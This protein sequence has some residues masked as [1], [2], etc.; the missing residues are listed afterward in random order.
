MGRPKALAELHVTPYVLRNNR[1]DPES[2]QVK[3]MIRG[4]ET[5]ERNVLF[6]RM[7]RECVFKPDGSFDLKKSEHLAVTQCMREACRY[8]LKGWHN[9]KQPV[10]D[11]ATRKMV[12]EEDLP[13]PGSGDASVRKIDND[14]AIELG[15]EILVRS[16][17]TEEESGN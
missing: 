16:R 9:L 6:Q 15:L 14:I 17:L 1:E 7:R 12:G 10:V 5:E 8:G 3:W 11:P 4:L 13:F 2:E